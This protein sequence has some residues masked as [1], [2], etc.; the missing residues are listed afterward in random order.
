M[1]RKF[2]LTGFGPFSK[3]KVNPSGVAVRNLD[4]HLVLGVKLVGVE[5]PVVFE[6]AYAT[7]REK[8]ISERPIGLISSGV[9]SGRAE[10]SIERVAL[11]VMDAPT[12]HNKGEK[13][14]DEPIVKNGPAA[15]LSTLPFRAILRDLS[16]AEIPAVISNTAGTHLCNYMMYVGQYHIATKGLRIPSGFIHVPQTPD[17]T[18]G[19]RGMPSMSLDIIVKALQ[20]AVRRTIRSVER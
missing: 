11:N 1:P 3:E 19:R 8:I 10:V 9:A 6:E 17:Q 16:K 15:Y 13:P 18:V 14:K 4:G 12:G 20:I 5:L 7:L 2:L